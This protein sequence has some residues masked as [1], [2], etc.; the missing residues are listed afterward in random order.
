MDSIEFLAIII[1]F[2]C[3]VSWYI[4]NVRSGSD[5]HA[6]LFAM[7]KDAV[8]PK[9]SFPRNSFRA[10]SSTKNAGARTAQTTDANRNSQIGQIY[11]QRREARYR[12]KG[13]ASRYRP[14][15][16]GPLH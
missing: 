12:V 5:G 1:V 7:R 4:H 3:I 6:G 15:K 16:A 14:K 11:Q 13:K 8:A 9:T 2:A 10:Q